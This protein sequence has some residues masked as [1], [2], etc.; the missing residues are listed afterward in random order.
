MS[1]IWV[2]LLAG[3]AGAAPE[4]QFHRDATGHVSV[5]L[6]VDAQIAA[7][8]GG[9]DALPPGVS[10]WELRRVD[11]QQLGPPIYV[12]RMR[13]GE[14]QWRLSPRFALMPGELYEAAAIYEGRRIATRHRIP[15]VEHPTPKLLRVAPDDTVPA[16]CLKFYLYFSEP[17][18]E[19]LEVFDLL[20]LEEIYDGDSPSRPARAIADPWRRVELWSADAKRLTLWIHPGRIKQGVNLREEFG[21]VLEPNREYALVV[22]KQVRSAAGVELD[23]EY[24]HRFRATAEDH[25]SPQLDDWQ[26]HLPKRSAEPLRIGTAE[27]LDH[28]QLVRFVH[29]EDEQGREVPGEIQVTN[30]VTLEFQPREP[31]RSGRYRLRVNA[32]LEDLAGNTFARVF[33]RDLQS[34]AENGSRVTERDFELRLGAP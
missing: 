30:A 26:L 6:T 18:R 1:L 23:R 27:P 19:G 31:W 7:R 14:R 34:G 17:M 8:A 33:D 15:Q 5:V 4:L 25:T 22:D 13:A 32:R 28:A 21:P 12:R 3:W 10:S 11:G 16:N 2:T 20:R 9:D 29:I 24:R